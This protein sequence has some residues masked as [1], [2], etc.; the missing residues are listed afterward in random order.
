MATPRELIGFSRQ[1]G[2][3]ADGR[4]KA[5]SADADGMG[6][7]EGVGMVLLERLSDA[8]RHGH[9]VLAVVAGSAMNQDGASNGLTAPNGPSQQRVIKE[10]LA[11]A[12]L[13]AGD[14]DVVEAHG[15]GTPLGDPIEAQALIAT[16]GQERPAGAPLWLGS[17]KSNIGH[18][19][20]AAGVAGVIKMVLA[21]Q[22]E[23]LPST[24]HVGEPSP[25][26]DWSAGTVRL[27]TESKAWPAGD[28]TRR[29][30][31]SG[32]GISGTNAHVVLEE[33]PVIEGSVLDDAAEPA[34]P[35]VPVLSGADASAWL[36]SG[37]SA[38]GLS[39]Q[40]G[41]LREFALARPEVEPG[42][43]A[44][45]LATSRSTFEHRAVIVG[46]GPDAL[47]AGL[48]ALAS[49]Q[50]APGVLSGVVRGSARVGFVFSGQGSQRA[51]MGAGLHAASPVFAE[52]FDRVCGLLEA[53]LGLPVRDVVLGRV[54]PEIGA[55]ATVFAQSGLFAFQVGVVT[56]LRAAGVSPVAV[57]G[58]SVGE[59]A[60]AWASG[61]L[62][63]ED[64][65]SLVATRA[66]LMQELPEGGAMWA[67]AAPEAEVLAS[68]ENVDGVSIAAVNGPSAT[69]ISGDAEAA[70]AVAEQWRSGGTRVRRLRVSHAF[71]S[72]RMDPVLDELGRAAA[73]LAHQ[74]PQL[75]WAC[76]TTGE[77]PEEFTP[78][79]WVEQARGAVRFGDAVS[80]LSGR[81]VQI[82]VEIGPD[83]TLSG[84]GPDAVPDGVFVPVSRAKSPADVALLEA[85]GR[86]H[87][88][89]GHVD[90]SAVL[91]PGTRTDLPTY[92]FQRQRF[93]PEISRAAAVVA[94]GGGAD[95]EFWAAVEDGDLGRLSTALDMDEH[96]P[97]SEALPALASWRRRSREDSAVA[98]WRYQ[99]TWAQV[100]DPATAVLTGTWLVVAPSGVPAQDH[101]RAL[102]E[103]GAETVLFEV[104]A[105]EADRGV[106]T[107]RLAALDDVAGVV[108]L[109]ALDD[110]PSAA[111][112]AVPAGV[113]ATITL[114]QALGDAG[115][116]A[117]M[118]ALTQ[119]AVSTGSGDAAPNPMQ[120]QV[121]GLG[122]VAGLEHADRWGGLVDLP[123]SWDDRTASRLCAVLAGI[124]EDQVA[125]RD[126]GVHGRRLLRAA[127]PRTGRTWTPG[128]T[129]LVTGGTGGIGRRV[130]LW[131]AGRGAQRVVLTSRSGP[132]VAGIAAVAAELATAGAPVEVIAS[133]ISQ[134]SEVE[135]LLARI[136]AD[137]PPLTSVMHAAGVGQFSSFEESSV[138]EHAAVTGAK[139]N[140]AAWLDELTRDMDLDAFVAFSSIAA[141]WGSGHQPSYAAGNAY[142][143]ALVDDRRSRGLAATSLAWGP[144]AGG[145]MTDEED[146]DRMQLRGLRLLDPRLAIQAL[147]QALDGRD[148]T[149]TV[150]D[151]EWERFAPLF[152]LRRPSPL[153]EALPEVQQ[154]LFAAGASDANA[155]D[156]AAGDLAERLAGLSRADQ[157][158]L[159][160]DLVRTEAAVALGY[161]SANSVEPDRAFSDLGFDSL[162]GVELRNRLTGV[163]GIPLSATAVFDYP[164]TTAL[165]SFLR[166]S[167]VPD[168]PEELPLLAELDK[169]ESMLTGSAVA[170]DEH[171][172]IT[173]RLEAVLARWREVREAAAGGVAVIEKLEGSSDDEV[174]D[175]IGKEFGIH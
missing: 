74:R 171:A 98:D 106:L 70:E 114:V 162:T 170:E 27:L 153:I 11:S 175:F 116:V 41:R 133:D 69:V 122:R 94:A 164:T 138:E 46:S 35:V 168:A 173:A 163:T 18:A 57:A 1:R 117:P 137:G 49:D 128:G 104:G 79:Y 148:A 135:G 100:P 43:V 160:I 167:V 121:W 154:S 19:Q 21:L 29:A 65:V 97:L 45:T 31:V 140:G 93:W 63:I 22:H 73:G 40:A 83:G 92:A 10:A 47:T 101:T 126:S 145:G 20:A 15:T 108:S 91:E 16:Y 51:G 42:D 62:T 102:N 139:V 166:Q 52:A 142:L 39:G 172:R 155:P 44:W 158:H 2:L 129:T 152:T 9:H 124:D 64:A 115:I 169:V 109:L 25:H 59:F 32:F 84:M 13:S 120:A 141:T 95:D 72:H 81:G 89:G 28:R 149:L 119:G 86:V 156:G 125:I 112:P 60:A 103:R 61:V 80:A 146:A 90:W 23:T 110:A 132:G 24:L 67:I 130:G 56:L 33:A 127:Q 159:L 3:A 78:G 7:G 50:S 58:H 150:A 36:V 165:A 12:S 8:R 105:D 147:G 34:E 113:A 75:P 143:D 54:E 131:A 48:G 4:S 161:P 118:W 88:A 55:D 107:E 82:F 5:F 123:A 76:G 157:D 71:H 37:R 144:W 14:V 134:R 6:M 136:A 87:V 174:F 26:V 53:E 77:V 85:L 99:V 68:I 151:V 66:R 30:G 96:L 38:E 17:V 111:S